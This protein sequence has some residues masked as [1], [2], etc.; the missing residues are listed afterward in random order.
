M[1]Y[2]IQ[3]SHD[4]PAFSDEKRRTRIIRRIFRIN[5]IQ[6]G[7]GY[8]VSITLKN[9]GNQTFN[10]GT[11][12]V[13]A[14]WANNQITF[15]SYPVKS[16]ATNES[17]TVLFQHGAL[18]KYF[19]LLFAELKDNNGVAV[20]LYNENN[21]PY[22][23]QCFGSVWA[24]DEEELLSRYALMIAAISLVVLMIKDVIIPIIIWLS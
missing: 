21:V 12:S 11:L 15:S 16:L 14:Q 7:S 17:F 18:D 6:V 22:I 4:K 3:I 20:T 24:I 9:T 8:K 1:T 10:G 2:L 5:D 19:G 23:G 13:R